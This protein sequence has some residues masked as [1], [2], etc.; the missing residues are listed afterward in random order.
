MTIINASAMYPMQNRC[1]AVRHT[2]DGTPC[3]IGSAYSHASTT[4]NTL[5]VFSSEGGRTKTHPLPET[6]KCLYEIH[7]GDF[8]G[9]YEVDNKNELLFMYCFSIS[10]V[11]PNIAVG[12]P[13]PL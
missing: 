13:A 4:E 5:F 2:S 12:T 1:F 6:G 9:V 3:I 10:R 8:V 7:P 11:T